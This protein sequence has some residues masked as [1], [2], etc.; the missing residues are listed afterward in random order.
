VTLCVASL[1]V[2][3]T[4]VR[5]LVKDPAGYQ[6]I[7]EVAVAV[8]ASVG[9]TVSLAPLAPGR[10]WAN[11]P[12]ALAGTVRDP[13]DPPSSLR[14]VWRSDRLGAVDGP[15]TLSPTGE[16]AGTLT[17]P[18]G[19]HTLTLTATDPGGAVGV[20]SLRA[21]IGPPDAP[22]TCALHLPDAVVAPDTAVSV[23]WTVLD[24]EDPPSALVVAL[25]SDLD[26]PL[27]GGVGGAGGVEV[28][29]RTVGE[30]VL[31]LEAVDPNGG[32]CVVS[33]VLTVGSPPVV[34]VDA[35]ADG[36][37]LPLGSP[38]TFA[39]RVVDPD[40]DA[41]AGTFAL[42]ARGA[43][44]LSAPPVGPFALQPDPAD[45]ARAVGQAAWALPLGEH[46][47]TVTV[48]DEDGLIA[49]RSVGLT[50]IP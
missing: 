10:R 18:E 2:G 29:L 26:G 39:V 9:P 35:P 30:Q 1:E 31:T 37:R 22:P 38:I 8:D 20:G 47:V 34:G 17:L 3:E 41:A 46:T 43:A 32:A 36:A 50:V 44:G 11:V 5:L 19:L 16:L 7:D 24:A 42:S 14:L 21:L 23:G 40:G 4:R 25:G 12:V 13:D 27:G 15:V 48:T 49:T 28:T 6:G 45:A 33:G